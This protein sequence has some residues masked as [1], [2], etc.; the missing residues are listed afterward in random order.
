HDKPEKPGYVI[1]VAEQPAAEAPAG[2]GAPP[3][4]PPIA[5]RLKTASADAGKK[6][7][8]KCTSCHNADKGGKNATGPN[9]WAVVDRAV[10]GHE[11]FT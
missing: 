11:G 8:A 6:V 7:F 1:A 9:L 2:A 10:A 4:A 5:E 3:A